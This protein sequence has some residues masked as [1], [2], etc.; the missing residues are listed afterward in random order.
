MGM[1]PAAEKLH[2]DLKAAAQA[3]SELGAGETDGDR[4]SLIVGLRDVLDCSARVL[5]AA[6]GADWLYS[7]QQARGLTS[8]A[9]HV[10]KAAALDLGEE[11]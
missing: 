11:P 4:A 2:A 8:A 9:A 7:V 6:Y 1:P 10:L 3:A 5:G